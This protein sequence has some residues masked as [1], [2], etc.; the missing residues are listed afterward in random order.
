MARVQPRPSPAVPHRAWGCPGTV[1][2]GRGVGVAAGVA[3][4]DPL[5]PFRVTS[6]GL[7]L[8]RL[9]WFLSRGGTHPWPMS[10]PM[11]LGPHSQDPCAGLGNLPPWGQSP[12]DTEVATARSPHPSSPSPQSHRPHQQP[13]LTVGETEARGG[14]SPAVC[15]ALWCGA[16]MSWGGPCQDPPWGPAVPPPLRAPLTLCP[17]VLAVMAECGQAALRAGGGPGGAPDS[18]QVSEGLRSAALGGGSPSPGGSGQDR[19][20]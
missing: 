17:L 15:P 8:P 18:S 3:V 19:H 6:R 5:R 7:V 20:G 10:P 11:S 9:S 4:Q 12:G 16:A 13:P 2:A 14:P 1:T